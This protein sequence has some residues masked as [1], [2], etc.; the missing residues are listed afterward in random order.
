MEW[1][2]VHILDIGIREAVI[3]AVLAWLFLRYSAIMISLAVFFG[4]LLALLIFPTDIWYSLFAL[5]VMGI[6]L[7]L[8]LYRYHLRREAL[9]QQM[10]RPCTYTAARD[11]FHR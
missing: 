3:Y 4:G 11:E 9:F 8:L 5:A 1:D 2:I 10:K 6:G 7:G